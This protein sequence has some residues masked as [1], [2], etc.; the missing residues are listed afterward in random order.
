MGLDLHSSAS[1]GF[2]SIVRVKK[3]KMDKGARIKPFSVINSNE[4]TIGRNGIVSSFVIVK[5]GKIVLGENSKISPFAI[6]MADLGKDSVFTLGNHSQVFPFC[7]IE[8]GQGVHIGNDTGIGGH[9]LIFTH[10]SWSDYLRGGPVKHAPVII[11][12]HVWLPWR[13]FVM[14]GVHVKSDTIIAGGSVLTQGT[15][16]EGGL[17]GGMPAK[18]LK[19]NIIHDLNK[20]QREERAKEIVKHFNISS[21]NLLIN[22]NCILGTENI[23]FFTEPVSL[24]D[25]EKCKKLGI[26]YLN[27]SEKKFCLNNASA[28]PFYNFVRKYGIRLDL[29]RNC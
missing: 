2:G 24:I 28:L 26:S 5:C 11:G 15:E 25:S 21:P 23:V 16:D 18:L 27:Y 10:G 12:D 6:I 22:I 13:V 19:K 14:P 9:T 7:W 20:E 17:Y 3:I 4:L 8:P 1:I 29:V